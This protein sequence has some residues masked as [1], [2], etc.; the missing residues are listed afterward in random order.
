MAGKV[1]VGLEDQ[2]SGWYP[3]VA[4]STIEGALCLLM[5]VTDAGH[6]SYKLKWIVEFEEMTNGELSKPVDIL[7]LVG[8]DSKGVVRYMVAEALDVEADMRVGA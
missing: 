7:R 3:A 5:E 6:P 2:E 4:A 1:W 8:R